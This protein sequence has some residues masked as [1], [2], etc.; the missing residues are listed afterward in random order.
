MFFV[1][2]TFTLQSLFL[3]LF[4]W[5]CGDFQSEDWRCNLVKKTCIAGVCRWCEGECKIMCAKHA[6]LPK[7]WE[8]K[9]YSCGCQK[10]LKEFG[11]SEKPEKPVTNPP[12]RQLK[13]LKFRIEHHPWTTCFLGEGRQHLFLMIGTFSRGLDDLWSFQKYVYNIYLY[14]IFIIFLY[15]II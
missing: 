7:N 9:C 14:F 4:I 1:G 6:G 5:Q 10:I 8:T 13:Q 15:N 3:F 11:E 2:P 12:S